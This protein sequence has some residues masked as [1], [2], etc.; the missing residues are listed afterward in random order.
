VRYPS[1]PILFCET[2]PLDQ[3]WA[4]RFLGAALDHHHDDAGADRLT[5]ALPAA[6]PLPAAPATPAQIRTWANAHG[7]TV[8][9]KGRIPADVVAAFEQRE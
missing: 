9:A 6:G 8:A 3:K 1:V 7:Y 4:Y 2:R 5:S